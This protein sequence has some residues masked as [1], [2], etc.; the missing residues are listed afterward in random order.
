MSILPQIRGMT[1]LNTFT[2][3]F[4]SLISNLSLVAQA[5]NAITWETEIGRLT[6]PSIARARESSSR[7][8]TQ[9]R[10]LK[11]KRGLKILPSDTVVCCLDVQDPKLIPQC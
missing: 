6:S 2:D 7:V 9:L 11:S 5:C 1:V 10:N 3:H 8:Y 4:Q